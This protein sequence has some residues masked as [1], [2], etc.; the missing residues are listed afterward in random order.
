MRGRRWPWALAAI[1][2]AGLLGGWLLWRGRRPPV[3][4]V[5]QRVQ[6]SGVLRVGL[7][8]SYPP[9]EYVDQETGEI[10]GYDVDLAMLIGE[11]LGVEVELINAGFDG[12]YPALKMGR[13]DCVISAFPYD[14]LL[15]RDVSFSIPYFQA[16]LMLVVR[17]GEA[18]IATIEDLQDRTLAVE[19]GGAGDVK[20]RELQKRL[21]DLS[22]APYATP[23]EALDAVRRGEADGA[24]VDSV[25]AYQATQHD[26]SL[27]IAQEKITDEPYV[28]LVPPNSPKF[29][30]AINGSLAEFRADSTLT[31]L[32]EKWLQ[33]APD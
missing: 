23:G 5:W 16:G 12:L 6:R 7:D 30:E 15:T 1:L 20:G 22:L 24:L 19:W 9:F 33:E 13:F 2:L 21:G 10:L 25:S 28:I 8:A 27:R 31:R 3:D 4:E 11:K 29:L 17:A 32:R 26:P 18:D 14:P